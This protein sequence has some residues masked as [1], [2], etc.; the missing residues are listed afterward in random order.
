[1]KRFFL[2]LALLFSISNLF[3]QVE[4]SVAKDTVF[5]WYHS[6]IQDSGYAGISL[7]K[8]EE[9]VK[10]KNLTPK[11]VVVAIIDSGIDTNH[12]DI[13]PNLWVNKGEI[14]YNGIDDDKNGYIDDVHG[15]DFLSSPTGKQV[16]GE[17]LEFTRLYRQLK[18]KY[19]DMNPKDVKPADK[20]EYDLYIKVKTQYEKELS[21]ANEELKTNENISKLNKSITNVLDNYFDD[22]IY[23]IDDVKAINTENEKLKSA[24][25]LY[26]LLSEAKLD[27]KS[28]SEWKENISLRKSKQ[29]NMLYNP[30]P[31]IVKDDVTNINDSI[32]GS[33]AL[34]C[35]K[36]SNHGTGVA[37]IVGAVRD[38]GIGLNG[39]APNVKLMIIRVVPGGD[40]YDKD[41]ALAI[42]YAVKMGAQIINCSF[43]KDY[44]PNKEF[45]DDAVKFAQAN[46]VLIVHAAGNDAKNIELG[47]NFPTKIF[48]DGTR[49]KNWIEVGASNKKPDLDFVASFSNYG[50]TLI[51]I[52]SPGVDIYGANIND[53][54]DFS[55]GTSDAAPVV[56]GVAAFVLSYYPNLS[57]EQLKSIIVNS[58]VYYGDVKVKIPSSK[59]K[60]KKAKFKKL[61]NS[62]RVV[63]LYNAV[64][65][66]DETK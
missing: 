31:Q 63:N 65:L 53:Q 37:S 12:I 22:Q 36:S 16:D 1:M 60:K 13:K 29:L 14:P 56:A 49:A 20:A 41:V 43:G 42:R 27:E 32:Y 6:D 34:F 25:D 47:D 38:N 28:L 5:L 48:N 2:P 62:G 52:Y 58:G 30:R 61:S 15:W 35:G 66:A 9:F 54:F 39:I 51:D 57:A 50:V 17:T 23:T 59:P 55:D 4:K 19:K 21:D 64:K 7:Q 10:S 45:V 44:S 24:K 46:N 18:P 26:I 40:E 11:E 8:A 33:N 3:S